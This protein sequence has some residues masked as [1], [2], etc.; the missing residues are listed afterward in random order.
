MQQFGGETIMTQSTETQDGVVLIIDTEYL[1]KLKDILR[2]NAHDLVEKLT[3]DGTSFITS[4]SIMT[5]NK[6]LEKNF[7]M[8]FSKYNIIKTDLSNSL[9]IG[10]RKIH[11]SGQSIGQIAFE[12]V[13]ENPSIGT[14]IFL[15]DKPDLAIAIE[16][17]TTLGYNVEL[18]GQT[19]TNRLIQMYLS[20][21]LDSS[22]DEAQIRIRDLNEYKE[23][24]TLS[25]V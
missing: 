15:T 21:G 12:C 4:N 9:L 2:I 3:N 1:F 17:L 6:M 14:V 11:I 24:A 7:N 16:T 23:L 5:S 18:V 8:L 13:A 22:E 10:S 25:V 20:S 19:E